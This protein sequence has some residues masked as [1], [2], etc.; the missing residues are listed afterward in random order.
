MSHWLLKSDPGTYSFDDLQRDKKTVWDGV[1]NNLALKH[2]RNMKKG[3]TAFVYHSGP[4][5]SVVGIADIVS[6]PFPDP[7]QKDPR[8]AVVE[9]KFRERLK[10]PVTLSA[11]RSDRRFMNFVLVRMSRLSVMPVSGE[12]WNMLL[13]MSR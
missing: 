5:K 2:I 4:E 8:L 10:N 7:K 6:N 12:Q 1:S 9:I 3:D 13:G 11:I